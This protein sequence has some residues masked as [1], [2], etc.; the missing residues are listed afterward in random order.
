MFR[1]LALMAALSPL[2]LA[3]CELE[4]S[5]SRISPT[6]M[7]RIDTYV[8]ASLNLSLLCAEAPLDPRQEAE[9]EGNANVMLRMA[10]Y[11]I[12]EVLI[13]GEPTVREELHSEAALYDSCMPSVAKRIRTALNSFPPP[14]QV[15]DVP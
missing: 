7:N 14:P 4:D 8:N 13:E 11:M 10:R 9:A 12:D 1:L 3:G 15:Y 5:G 6:E 2:L